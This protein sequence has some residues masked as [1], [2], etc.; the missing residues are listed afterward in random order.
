MYLAAHC[1]IYFFSACH[2]HEWKDTLLSPGLWR[3]L[4]VGLPMVHQ[5]SLNL[6]RTLAT[7]TGTARTV[8]CPTT[9]HQRLSFLRFRTYPTLSPAIPCLS[10]QHPQGQH[11]SSQSHHQSRVIQISENRTA[12]ANITI[13]WWGKEIARGARKGGGLLALSGSS[14]GIHK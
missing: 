13:S 12:M 3:S 14:R 9:D 2:S 11:H 1:W 6:F 8:P 10:H 7:S 4:G 5:S